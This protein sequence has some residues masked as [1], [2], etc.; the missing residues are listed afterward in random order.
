MRKL[1]A[2]ATV[3]LVGACAQQ[4]LAGSLPSVAT[5]SRPGPDVLYARPAVAPQ[6]DNAGPWKADPIL[7]SGAAAYRDGEYL[8]QDYLYDDHGATGT[9]DP[10]NPFGP[11][12]DTYSPPAGSATYPT[13]PVYGGNA[14][15]LVEFR[16]KPLADATAFRVTLNTLEDAARTGF[17]IAIGS[18]PAAVAWPHGAGV[19]SPAQLFLTVHGA[20]AELVDAA[21]GKK[22]AAPSVSTDLTRRQVD[23]RV[24]HSTWDPGNAVVRM[25][26]GVGLWDT[27]AD[28]YLAP[29]PGPASDSTP[30]G[31][32]PLGAALFNVGPRFNEPLP[33]LKQAPTYSAADAAVGATVQAAWWREKEQA[34]ALAT[35]DISEFHADVDFSKLAAR[36][37]D[38]SGVPKTG[39]MNR[40]LASHYQFGQGYDG[41]KVCFVIGGENEGANCIGRMVGQLQPYTIYVPKKP[42]PADG[43]GMTLLL[44]SLSANYNQY[45]SSNNQSQLGERGAGS[46]V[47]TP[48]GRGPDGFYA[49]YA[50]ADTFEVWAD[51]AR[52][53]K[54]Y[55]DWTVVTGY[56]MGGFGTYR[57]LARY[58]DLFARGFSVV[59][60]PGTVNDQL[61]S[62]RNTPIMAWN[63]VADELVQINQ[64]EQ[65]VTDM[66]AAG[67]RF[68]EDLFPTA[69]HLTLATNDEYGK[70]ADWLGSHR[71]DRNPPHVTF[72][73][74]PTED[75]AAASVVANHAYW[76]SGTS[77]RDP[78]KS[79]TGTFDARSEGFGVG[80]GKPTGV[81]TGGGTLDGGAHGPTPYIERSQDWTPAPKEPVADRLDVV[82]TNIATATVDAAR[83]R[84][85]CAP[86][87][88]VKSDGP[89]DL[90][91]DC[92][93]SV[94]KAARCTNRVAFALPRVKGARIVRAV[95]TRRGKVIA[96]AKGRNLRS[97]S[98]KR[99]SHKA[100][101]VR[102]TLTTSAKDKRVTVVRRVSP[103]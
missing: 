40:I 38:D 27:A 36:T 22:L 67:L 35:G 14:A 2:I 72:V 65:A 21:S 47:I 20:T 91:I 88:N 31:A 97:L 23:V 57:L 3:T 62:L 34:T 48:A 39:T 69:D 82:A 45:S 49:G 11:S 86:Q 7:V 80:D 84:L 94:V 101:S 1:L 50:E 46:I 87:L 8:Y 19:S 32:S 13:D 10:N 76:A 100:F 83:A 6:L 90:R 51:V 41:S 89:L 54:L 74:D 29:Q 25:E 30:G 63:A 28:K 37:D 78:K 95:V 60:I 5:G 85:S 42:Q 12:P 26:I 55:P 81:A 73:V 77:V 53:Y 61:A 33:D 64:S 59:G 96:R 24:P 44:H 15:D 71:V 79:P 9:P 102:I 98:L 75:A 99:V 56:S 93:K 92:T 4:A 103:C 52:R 70:G 18:S 66:T 58:P 16:I 43:Y 68:V 17:T